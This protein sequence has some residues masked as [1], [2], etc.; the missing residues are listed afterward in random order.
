MKLV[1]KLKAFIVDQDTIPKTIH[2]HPDAL[3]ELEDEKF[4]YILNKTKEN[5]VKRFM[6]IELIPSETVT[7]FTVAEDDQQNE[8]WVVKKEVKKI[9]EKYIKKDSTAEITKDMSLLFAYLGYLE[10]ELEDK[11]NYIKYLRQTK[12]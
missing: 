11:T 8:R 2:I 10:R 3:K 4:V 1:D 6:G 9:K 7:D 12:E 5:P